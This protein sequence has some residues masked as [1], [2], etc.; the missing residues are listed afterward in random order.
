MPV[1][2]DC[3]AVS[4]RFARSANL[5]RDAGYAE[6][7]AGYVVTARALDV[8][9]RIARSAAER[10]SGGAWSLTG[11]YGS[12]KSSLAL[13]LDAAFS[14]PGETRDNAW[15][16]IDDASPAVGQLV[17]K[18][19]ERHGTAA[20]GFHRAL[21][22]AIV[23]RSHIPYSGHFTPPFSEP[24]AGFRP[25]AGSGRLELCGTPLPTP[26]RETR[27]EPGPRSRP[28]STL[29]GVWP[30]RRRYS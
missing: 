14:P 1:L 26:R 20:T 2:A 9:E 16:L 13:L 19:H 15:Q 11:P 3:I 21:V 18:A 12:G 4:G 23:N 7:L 17:R 10:P 5:E 8:V 25:Q 24:T 6:P 27:A 22:T 29:P 28:W 30:P